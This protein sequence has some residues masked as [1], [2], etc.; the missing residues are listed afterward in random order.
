[1]HFNGGA[2]CINMMTK[3]VF[4]G[5]STSLFHNN[6]ATKGGGA[7]KV[8]NNSSFTLK[9]YISINFTNNTAQYIWWCNISRFNYCNG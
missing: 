2:I 8:L 9:D 6:L 4:K 3:F 5:N 7:V 1:M